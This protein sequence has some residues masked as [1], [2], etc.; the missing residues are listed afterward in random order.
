MSKHPYSEL[1]Q[2]AY[3]APA[4][5]QCNMFDIADLWSPKFAI[6]AKD[7]IATFGSCFAQHISRALIQNGYNWFNA[8]QG[9]KQ[10]T[11]EDNRKFNYGVF[12]ART[13]NIYTASLLNQWVNWANGSAQEPDEIWVKDGRVYDPFRPNVEPQGFESEDEMR[14]SRTVTINAFRRCLASANVLVFTLGLTESW[15]NRKR[16]FEYPL[17]PGTVAGD[18]DA[19]THEFVNQDY[20]T[21]RKTL[22]S[23]IRAIMALNP[24]IRVLLT[25]SPVPLTATMSGNHVLVATM[26]SKS[27]LRAVAGSIARQ[28]PSV[29][30]FPSYEIISAFPFRGT[31]F[32]S[33]LRSVN[34]SGVDHV[35]KTFFAAL[36][37]KGAPAPA[38]AA[39]AARPDAKNPQRKPRV[40]T[41]DDE[42]ICEEEL[43]G[44]FAQ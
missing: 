27:I 28:I 21:I 31:F 33:N 11:D 19:D 9:P 25:V 15:F 34:H 37:A 18:F 4:V 13:G 44:A 10:F 5:G 16:D 38:D 26:E 29:D 7:Q 3:W 41:K 14:R 20:N 17:C 23:A 42:V 8:E 1:P 39:T 24:K 43:L 12:S 36:A 6:R 2:S 40:A 22:G 35:M 32:E 30:Y